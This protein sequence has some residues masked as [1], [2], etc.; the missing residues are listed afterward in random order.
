[1][2]VEFWF[3]GSDSAHQRFL[4]RLGRADGRIGWRILLRCT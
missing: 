1:V 2:A 3:D 4:L